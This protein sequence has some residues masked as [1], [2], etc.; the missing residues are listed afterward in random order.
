[1]LIKFASVIFILT[2]SIFAKEF[3]FIAIGDTPYSKKEAIELNESVIPAI[4]EYNSEFVAFYGD[5]KSGGESCTDE[6]IN[7][8]RDM[9]MNLAPERVFYTPGDNE[10][11]DCDRDFLKERFSELER[12]DYLKKAFFSKPLN[13]PKD[14]DYKTQ[15][16]F[17]EN[18]RWT[19]NE[20]Q[21]LT[22]HMVSTNNGRVDILKDDIDLALSLVEARDQANRNWMSE[23]FN[24]AKDSNAKAVV[25]ITQ[26]D[27][28][29]PDSGGDCDSSNK[30]QCDAFKKF[31]EQ[32]FHEAKNFT[33]KNKNKLPVLL[34]HGDTNPYCMDKSFGGKKAPNLWR[35]N[36]W[37]DFQTPADATVV[38]ID[39][40][41]KT[42]FSATTLVHK[43]SPTEGCK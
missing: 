40:D 34:I 7:A 25:I 9:V 2:L 41:S 17:T 42:P 32:L 24:N 27:V 43:K 26:A 36:A 31:R 5:L 12:L 13:L 23:A 4:K 11:T 28:T 10:W 38:T 37:G 20:I 33:D 3:S 21:F 14:W 15:P 35:L 39:T 16:N 30:M 18:A 22:L 29:N 6:L 19:H 1:M 8:R